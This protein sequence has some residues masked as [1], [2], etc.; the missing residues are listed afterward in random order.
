M[1]SLERIYRSSRCGSAETNLT[2][3]HEDAGP[4]PGLTDMN[5]GVGHRCG[6][7]MGLLWLGCRPT[8]IA[9]IR[10]LAWEPLYDAGAALKINK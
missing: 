9:L 3:I 8:A 2:R 5:S 10:P 7:D 4:I 1:A 6:S